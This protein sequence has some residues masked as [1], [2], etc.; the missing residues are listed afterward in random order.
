ML[1][2]YLYPLLP[3]AGP[4]LALND[5]LVGLKIGGILQAAKV[6][7]LLEVKGKQVLIF[8]LLLKC[9]WVCCLVYV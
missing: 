8:S 3:P 1:S 4:S 6:S 5:L 9:I 7:F 2:C